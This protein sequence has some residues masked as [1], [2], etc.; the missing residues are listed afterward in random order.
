MRVSNFVT[1]VLWKWKQSPDGDI[2]DCVHLSHQP[3]FDHPDLKSHKIQVNYLTFS[4]NTS[5]FKVPNLYWLYF[6]MN[7]INSRVCDADEAKFP[8]RRGYF[9]RKQNIFKFQAFNSAMAEKWE[10]PRRNNSY[11]KNQKRWC[12]ESKLNSAIWK[13]K[14]K[15]CPS[16]KTCKTSTWH[17]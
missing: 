11:Q 13:E 14:A 16:A 8:P 7:L 2:I 17:T 10:V 12:I 9:W 6:F 15:E 4:P 1:F 5:Q 3:A